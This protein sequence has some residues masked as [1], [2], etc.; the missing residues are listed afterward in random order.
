VAFGPQAEELV[1]LIAKHIVDWDRKVRGGPGMVVTILPAGTPAAGAT[2]AGVE[3]T[4]HR[5]ITLTWP[6]WGDAG[7]DIALKA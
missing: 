1:D 7:S 6:Q 2:E 4:R 3:T 5:R